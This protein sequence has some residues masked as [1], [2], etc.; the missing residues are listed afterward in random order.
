MR[1]LGRWRVGLLWFAAVI[2]IALLLAFNFSFWRE[3]AVT[4]HHS[5]PGAT[6]WEVD[7][8]IVRFS[9]GGLL[10]GTSRWTMDGVGALDVSSTDRR[11]WRVTSVSH[12]LPLYPRIPGESM[13][14]G[15]Q[16]IARPWSSGDT[17]GETQALVVPAIFPICVLGVTPLIAFARYR[18][19]KYL[20]GHC[21]GCGY[22]V[23]ASPERCPECGRE[24]GDA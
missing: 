12:R 19:Q 21:R 10:V 20:P 8:Y 4:L 22:D 17:R 16:R 6:G 11:P 5:R 2:A 13:F 1:V 14:F 9:A 3:W 7:N 15:F 23:R 18:R 24:V